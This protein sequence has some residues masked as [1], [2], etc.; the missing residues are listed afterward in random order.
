MKTYTA[1]ELAKLAGVTSRTIRY[2]DQRGLLPPV[3]HSENGYRLYD[4]SA[5]VKM[6][7]I[8]MLK[9]AGFS[10]E[11]IRNLLLMGQGQDIRETLEDQRQLLVQRIGQLEEIVTLLEDMAEENTADMEQ[12]AESM[13]L[14]R[15]VNHSARTYRAVKAHSQRPLYP[16]EFEQLGLTAGSRV[17]DVGCG[18]GMIWRHSW[19]QIPEGTEITMLDVHPKCI[20]ET[21]RYYEEQKEQL[22]AG[23]KFYFRQENAEAAGITEQYDQILMAYLWHYLKD[24]PGL[25]RKLRGAL[26]DGGTLNVIQGTAST[27][28][29]LDDIWRAYA[30]QSCLQER[31]EREAGRVLQI[32]QTLK[33]EFA[34]VEVIPFENELRFTR[35]LDLYQYMMDSYQELVQEMEKQGTK[36]VNFLR[37][38]VEE[39]GTVTL[40]SRV[41][42]WRCKKE[43]S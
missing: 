9:F 30:G 1:G 13:R 6:Q 31:M 21:K 25:L 38:Y 29:G 5:L 37:K 7:Q 24:W 8:V 23:V 19:E 43:E 40:K 26:A 35:T 20:R 10:L 12:L 33:A 4:D 39:Q 42:L 14:T 18:I 27:L 41:M 28:Q 15:R 16:W 3:G 32:E 2:Y 22:R 34:Q 11:E 17:L 36:F